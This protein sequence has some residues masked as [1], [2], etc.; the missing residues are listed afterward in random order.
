MSAQV[1]V[2][3]VGSGGREHAIAVKLRESPR[4]SHVFCAPGNGGTA[5]ERDMTNVA[6]K[7]SDIPGLVRFATEKGVSLV[8]V[9]P[10]IPLVEGLVDAC[11]GAGIRCFGPSKAAAE[12]EASKAFSKQ[13]FEKYGLPTAAFR[14]FKHGE[15]DAAVAYVRGEYAA[16]REVVVKAS[17]LAA[18]KGVLMPESLDEALRDLKAVMLDNAFGSAG[19]EVVIEQLLVGEEVSCMAFTDGTHVAMMPPAQD[20]K[21]AHDGDRGLNTGGMGAYA[22]A[23]CLTPRLRREVLVIMERTVKAM[24]EEGRVYRGVLYGGFMLTRDGPLVL[25]YNCRFGD[26]ETQVLLPLLESDLFEICAACVDG[27]LDRLSLQWKS[28]SAATVVCAAKGYP[29][30]YAKGMAIHGL[31]EAGA[32]DEIKIYHAGTV[33]TEAG[34][35]TSG[36]RVLAVTGQAPTFRGAIEAA[37]RGVRSI[38]FAPTDGMHFRQDIGHRALTRPVCVAILGSTRG[39]ASQ[40]VLDA[41]KQGK[42]NAKVGV[43]VSNVKDAGIL[44]RAESEGVRGVHV[45]C[46]KGTS[47]DAFDEEVSC[48]LR[49]EGVDLVMLVGFMRILGPG[50]CQEW[51]HRVLNVHPSLLPKHAGLMDLDV[52][53]SVLAAKDT[54]SGCTVH[55]AAEKVDAGRVIVQRTVPVDA[56]DTPETLKAKVQSE[57]GPALVE[58]VRLFSTAG[59]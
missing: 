40:V 43:I 2:L 34:F 47:R 37:Y 32:T 27:D 14:N 52:H 31:H 21:R 4:V 48:I 22:P 51:E 33:Q 19:E 17:G 23:P 59:F 16:S 3:L 50:F 7:D 20:H 42:L 10:E 46:P 1:E 13:L 39:S 56:N 8:F 5:S 15:Y 25:E 29:E 9:G 26:P 35:A 58:A 41:I 45:P 57:E 28:A 30:S 55:L 24:A 6:I 38:S 36:G 44:A 12:L 11:A 54:E 49:D 18:G 53:R